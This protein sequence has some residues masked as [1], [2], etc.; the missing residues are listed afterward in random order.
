MQAGKLRHR[1]LLQIPVNS[2]DPESGAVTP[3]WQDVR[4]LWAEVTPLSVREFIAS[5]AGQSEIS[6][7]IKIRRRSDITSKHR[8][9][10]RSQIYNIEGVLPDPESGLEYLTLPC[11][12]GVN[13]G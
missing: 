5:Q 6:A 1:V 3:S 13:D 11:S 8:L 7:R 12:E 4:Y 9:I 10:F 2:Q